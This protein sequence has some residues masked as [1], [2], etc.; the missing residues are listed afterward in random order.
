[1]KKNADKRNLMDVDDVENYIIETLS[2]WNEEK[3]AVALQDVTAYIHDWFIDYE[4]TDE[5]SEQIADVIIDY[6]EDD[7]EI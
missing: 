7:N 2:E 1:M 5:E 4:L 3:R 6:F